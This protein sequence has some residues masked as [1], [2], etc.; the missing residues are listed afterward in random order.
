MQVTATVS[1]DTVGVQDQFQLTVTIVG[2]D[3][4]QAQTPRLPTFQGFKV[5]AGPSVSTQ[6][7]WINGQSSSSKSYIYILLPDKEGQFTIDPIEVKVGSRTFRTK[8]I[9]VRV[10]AASRAPATAPLAKTLPSDPLGI[11]D[12]GRRG[13]PAGE[14]VTVAAEL[15]RPAVFTGQQVTLSYHLYTQ[16]NVTGLQL[17]ENPPLTGFWVENLEVPSKPIPGRRVINGKEYLDYV[18][19]KQALFPNAAGKL[20]IPSSTFAISVKSTGDLFGFFAQADTV[21][22]KTR[23]ITLE[24]KPLPEKNRPE[25]FHDAVGSYALAGETDKSTAA[26]GDAVALRI[27]LSGKGNLKA[28][29]ELPLPAMPDLSIYSSKHEDSVHPVDGDLI[30]GEK[31]WEYV[32]VPKVPGDHVIPALSFTYF[33]PEHQTYETVS[34]PSLPLSV[35]RG[36]DNGNSL[37][38]LSGI[39]K[40]QLTRQGTDINFIK[41][42]GESFEAD[43]KPIYRSP[44]FYLLGAMPLLFNIGAYLHQRQRARQSGDATLMRGRK[45]RRTAWRRLHRAE[46]AGQSAPRHFYDQAAAA[47]AGYL[48]DRFNLPGIA[49]TADSLERTMDERRIAPEIVRQTMAALQ[50]C[51]FGRFVSASAAP[52]R[53]KALADQIR[54][55]ID[56]LELAGK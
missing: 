51:D 41:L 21:Y 36:S 49:V 27:K 25:G 18:V 23:E 31:V 5:V 2:D 14:E 30:G 33:D 52:E 48:E 11:D 20:K 37:G 3:T 1:T 53:R 19:K 24:V 56:S 46:A 22:R 15:D 7:Q 16:V 50:E 32:I 54:R 45:A 12:L 6:F 26:T 29:P 34:T 47:L 13:Q 9:S 10:T 8:P 39:Q 40:Q 42:S 44:W 43:Q 38:G 28:I 4:S 35:T 55:I 17:Q